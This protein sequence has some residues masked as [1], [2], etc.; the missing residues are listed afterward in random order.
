M[1]FTKT[2]IVRCYVNLQDDIQKSI[3]AL[4]SA[5]NRRGALMKF[6]VHVNDV[7]DFPYI[8]PHEPFTSHKTDNENMKLY[9][10]NTH[11][12]KI[13]IIQINLHADVI[14]ITGKS[15]DE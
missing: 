6:L 14:F 9:Y 1:A 15:K 4:V 10:D 5:G 8:D 7:K 2:Y 3:Y 13:E 11:S 12:I